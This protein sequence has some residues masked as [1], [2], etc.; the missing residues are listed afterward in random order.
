[1]GDRT[2]HVR[3]PRALHPGAHDGSRQRASWVRSYA[4]MITGAAGM[5]TATLWVAF[6][7]IPRLRSIDEACAS[8]PPR[9]IGPASEHSNGRMRTGEPRRDHHARA[10]EPTR[11]GRCQDIADEV[12]SLSGD[13]NAGNRQAALHM[14]VPSPWPERAQYR[15]AVD[16]VANVHETSGPGELGRIVHH[17][18][19]P[20]AGGRTAAERARRLCASGATWLNPGPSSSGF[21]CRVR[22][23]LW[24]W[25]RLGRLR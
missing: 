15:H 24:L 5:S 13:E 17:R 10:V 4:T 7:A 19:H 1:M 18:V 16:G 20:P 11:I 21:A 22:V 3:W 12:L 8:W 25:L 23:W 2:C 14:C 6:S 9:L